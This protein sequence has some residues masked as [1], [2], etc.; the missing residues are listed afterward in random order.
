[1]EARD[2]QGSGISAIGRFFRPGSKPVATHRR[3]AEQL[4]CDL[5]PH[6]DRLYSLALLM[7]GNTS[8]A[9]DLV[10]KT[11]TAAYASL[12]QPQ[13][14]AARKARLY[15]LLLTGYRHSPPPETPPLAADGPDRPPAEPS[16]GSGLGVTLT[17]ALHRLPDSDIKHALH[18]L[19]DDIRIMVYLADVEGY[20]HTEIADITAIPTEAVTA[21]LRRGRRQLRERLHTY[22]TT[23][24]PEPG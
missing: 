5:L 15:R 1:M 13:A 4:E 6:L 14:G 9:E 8:D 18:Q 24:T 20:S 11:V 17:E 22:A 23:P 21:R 2:C 7:T 12:P 16:T 10:E 3:R 19:P